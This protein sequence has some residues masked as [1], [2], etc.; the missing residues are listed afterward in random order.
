MCVYLF[1][2]YWTRGTL[3]FPASST[4]QVAL[5]VMMLSPLLLRGTF[6]A[7][8]D[9]IGKPWRPL[10]RT[11]RNTTPQKL[12]TSPHSSAKTPTRSFFVLALTDTQVGTS[13]GTKALPQNP[14]LSV[15]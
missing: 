11:R 3:Q 9:A 10:Q 7:T 2:S 4:V 15:G 6:F 5:D 14:S 12:P 13:C 8:I 1:H